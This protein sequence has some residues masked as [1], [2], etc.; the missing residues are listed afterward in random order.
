ML[1]LLSL[2]ILINYKL[3]LKIIISN[4]SVK[5]FHLPVNCISRVVVVMIWLWFPGLYMYKP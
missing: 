5:L 2:I 1:V 4:N 3:I